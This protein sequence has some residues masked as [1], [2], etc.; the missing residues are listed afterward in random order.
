MA[1]IVL[2]NV[3]AS[4]GGSFLGPIGGMVGYGIGSMIGGMVDEKILAP[5]SIPKV[6]GYRLQ[7][8]SVQT[9]TYGRMIPVI[10]GSCRIAGNIIWALPIKETEN[11]TTISAKMG[12]GKKS[13]NT[14]INYSYSATIAIAIC[15]GVINEISR[16]W[17]DGK[18]VNH[19][20]GNYRIYYGDEEQKPDPLM[21]AHIGVDKT[22]AYRGIAYIVIEDLPL[23]DF[24]NHIPNFT[25]EVNKKVLNKDG[26]KTVEEM[27]MGM[28]IIPGSGEFAYDTKVQYKARGQFID[29]QFYKQG[30]NSVINVN[31]RRGKADSIL[32]MEQ[33]KQTCP[34]LK[35]TS[36]VATWFATSLDIKNNKILPMVEYKDGESSLESWKV[37]KYN[38][39]NAPKIK[40]DKSNR[41]LYGGTPSDTSIIRFLDLQKKMG[42]KSMFYPMIFVHEDN[43]PWR[44]RI[45]GSSLDVA[46]FFNKTGGYND[47]ILHYA[48]L[49]KGKIDAFIIGSELIGLTKIC[50]ENNNFPAIIELINL[51]TKVKEILGKDVIV[52]Y[53]ADW[54][55]YH[56]TSGGWFNLDPLW[57]S[58]HIDVVGI[59]A[60]FPLT[61]EAQ[62]GYDIEKIKSGWENGEG[63]DFYYEDENRIIK[64]PLDAKYAWKNIRYWWENKHYNPDNK[65]TKWLPKMKPIWFTEYGFPSVN[66]ATNQPNIFYDPASIEGGMPRFSKGNIDMYIQRLA[67]QATE[68]YWENSDMVTNKFLWTWDARPYP[69]WPD[70]RHIWS[71]GGLWRTGHWVSGK[72]G[73]SS[74]AAIIQDLMLR[75]GLELKHLDT[76]ELIDSV[77]GVVICHQQSIRSAIEMLQQCYFFDVVETDGL[78][79]FLPRGRNVVTKIAKND[80]ISLQETKKGNLYEINRKQEIELPSKIE[81]LFINKDQ[82]YAQGVEAANRQVTS[83]CEQETI[84]LSI[85]LPAVRAKEIADISL[86]NTWSEQISYNFALPRKYSY[87]E[88]GDVIDVNINDIDAT[89]RII[90]INLGKNGVL[91]VAAVNELTSIYK[92]ADMLPDNG[93]DEQLIRHTGNNIV[94]IFELPALG[95]EDNP[96]IFMAIYGDNDYWRGAKIFNRKN[97]SDEM[98]LLGIINK[99]TCCG[100]VTSKIV[101]VDAG[102]IDYHNVIEV[103]LVTGELY[104]KN[105]EDILSGENI[106]LIG[107]EIIQFANAKMIEPFKYQLSVLLRGR[108][109]TEKYINHHQIGDRFVLLD[110]QI[111]ANNADF[112]DIG[113]IQNFHI[114]AIG[115]EDGGIDYQY[116]FKATALKPLAPVHLKLSGNKL[117]WVRRAR[118]VIEWKDFI[119][120]PVTEKSEKYLVK[121]M[122][123]ENLISEHYVNECEFTYDGDVKDLTFMVAQ[124]SDY[125][126]AGEFAILNFNY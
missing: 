27:V 45:T 64:K 38:R 39:K 2:G 71:D 81:V 91:E 15:E 103:C 19:H 46:N 84:N 112:N 102:F 43:K 36:I 88:V 16:V 107:N 94:D 9:S 125:V 60:Y 18:L 55:E 109:G 89:V 47:F 100:F 98:D 56:H 35:W 50:D 67:I 51:A 105:L 75:A 114:C 3:A 95:F 87:L 65:V 62:S 4:I 61:D 42:Y 57:A 40:V 93:S 99:A 113:N 31:N 6:R 116:Q 58:E 52:T 111:F 77:D 11:V 85:V 59:D 72:F 74:L 82:D 104:S 7:D 108:A 1:S 126:G 83:S 17:A 28:N 44:G 115:N 26:K 30:N 97:K 110:N 49:V 123:D 96:Y 23:A 12:K 25:F 86:Y 122:Y 80:L 32:A 24:G 8:L 101:N 106:A 118:G 5:R 76:S 34:N 54:S 29:G 48:K 37:A 14:Y 21:Q 33:L 41:P 121:I 63:Y 92:S 70:L 119:D 124:I 66:G 22:P 78:L 10:Y 53:S 73:L 20:Q 120:T 79:K 13:K 117:S 90:D 69:A 68:E